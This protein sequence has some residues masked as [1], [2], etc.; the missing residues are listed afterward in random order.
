MNVLL[1]KFGFIC[2]LLC[3]SLIAA[4]ASLYG[5]NI[6]TKIQPK[7]KHG[8]SSRGEAKCREVLESLFG[9]PFPRERPFFLINPKTGRRL[10]LDCY[11]V[12]IK[13]AVEYNGIQHYKHPNYTRQSYQSFLDQKQR[14]LVKVD[15]CNK[16]GIHLIVVPYTIRIND[17]KQY[18][19]ERLPK[20]LLD[21]SFNTTG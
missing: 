12:D 17:I 10:E 8:K 13:L 20:H 14:D 15:I 21:L 18:I 16:V 5:L 19:I 1:S 4:I 11:N 7:W 9:L 2:L 6:V 3:F